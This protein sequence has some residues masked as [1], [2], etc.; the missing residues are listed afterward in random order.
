MIFPVEAEE[1]IK[2]LK[3]IPLTEYGSPKWLSQH[4]YL[5][6]LNLQTHLS[7]KKQEDEFVKEFFVTYDK[8]QFLV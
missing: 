6:K 3:L 7:A 5:T 4:E 1:M 8:V 2:S